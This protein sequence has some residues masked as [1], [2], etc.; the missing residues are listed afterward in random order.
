MCDYF[1]QYCNL[2]DE[3]KSIK[4]TGE[5][6]SVLLIKAIF[7]ALE[8]SMFCLLSWDELPMVFLYACGYGIFFFF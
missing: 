6:Q 5:I 7:V 4:H 2:L 3:I 8:T 1:W